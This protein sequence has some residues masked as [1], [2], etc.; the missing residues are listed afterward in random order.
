[1]S[2]CFLQRSREVAS[3]REGCGALHRECRVKLYFPRPLDRGCR[4]TERFTAVG[5]LLSGSG[6][7]L[8]AEWRNSDYPG[9]TSW[10]GV[11]PLLGNREF[12]VS[13]ADTL[14]HTLNRQNPSN[15]HTIKTTTKRRGRKGIHNHPQTSYIPL[16]LHSSLLPPH[17][18]KNY[19]HIAS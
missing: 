7:G 18:P 6:D 10:A 19:I 17:S 12:E 15:R 4:S 13:S 11:I 8:Q 5:S 14:Q 3:S 1:M 9:S 2:R 16:L